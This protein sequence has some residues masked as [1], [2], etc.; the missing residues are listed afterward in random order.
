MTKTWIFALTFAAAIGS[1]VMGGLFFTFSNFVMAALA[2]IAPPQGIAAMQSI[3]VMVQN[4]LFFIAFFG[5][6][7]ACLA[8]VVLS[9]LRWSEPGMALIL[10]SSLLYLVGSIAV[11][12]LANVPLNNALAPLDP[13]S[14]QAAAF[15]TEFVA[16]WTWW[17][18]VRSIA[19]ILAMLGFV[20]ALTRLD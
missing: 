6:A 3:N 2:R 18:H 14:T 5:T 8:L 1:G 19:C 9:F 10:L 12:V 17:N 20:L 13:Q 11:T 15:W 16:R 7:L 4:P